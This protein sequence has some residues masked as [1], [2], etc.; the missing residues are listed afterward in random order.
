ME[1]QSGVNPGFFL[2][3]GTHTLPLPLYH[4][5][6]H[7]SNFSIHFGIFY[8]GVVYFWKIFMLEFFSWKKFECGKN[9]RVSLFPYPKEAPQC[10]LYGAE[11]KIFSGLLHLGHTFR[12]HI[13]NY[14]QKLH[15][16]PHQNYIRITLELLS[17][18][19]LA[20][21]YAHQN[22]IRLAYLLIRL[23]IVPFTPRPSFLYQVFHY[24]II[25]F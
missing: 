2:A 14:I 13:Q 24:I 15:F 23:P 10:P 12:T 3:R 20:C 8:I 5:F 21:V 11:R 22:Y 4:T 1:N 19:P 17:A 25:T 9:L 7:L 18:P 16:N 6:S